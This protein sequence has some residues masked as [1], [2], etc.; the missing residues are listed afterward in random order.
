MIGMI[1]LIGMIGLIDVIGF[2]AIF[3]TNHS[4]L[5]VVMHGNFDAIFDV[6]LQLSYEKKKPLRRKKPGQHTAPKPM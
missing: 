6:L 3:Y 4:G 1:V 5:Y 2:I